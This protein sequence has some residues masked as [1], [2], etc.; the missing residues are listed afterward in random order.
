MLL[1]CIN[2][3]AHRSF[4]SP[5]GCRYKHACDANSRRE[6]KT[7]QLHKA[8]EEFSVFCTPFREGGETG[9]R[10]KKFNY[11]TF[12]WK[13]WDL[14]LIDCSDK[15]LFPSHS[16]LGSQC[17][18]LYWLRWVFWFIPVRSWFVWI[19]EVFCS[20]QDKIWM[21]SWGQL[22]SSKMRDW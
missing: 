16:H 3:L 9:N 18:A 8:W 5:V 1:S 4:H 7:L 13:L 11:F 17:Q 22:P 21:S 6:I 20:F 12:N 14:I 2:S 10:K 15:F 19:F